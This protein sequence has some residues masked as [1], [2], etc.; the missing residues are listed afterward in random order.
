VNLL[1]RHLGVA[2]ETVKRAQAALEEGI[3][4]TLKLGT[5]EGYTEVLPIRERIH[6]NRGLCSCREIALGTLTSRAETAEGLLVLL[7]INLRLLLELAD[8]VVN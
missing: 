5:S 2:E 8:T 7:Q 1:L 3:T 6:L 4:Q